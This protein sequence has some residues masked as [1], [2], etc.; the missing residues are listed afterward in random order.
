MPEECLNCSQKISDGGF[1]SAPNR[2]L[3]F[4]AVKLANFV[5]DAHYE[6]LCEACGR[7]INL[8]VQQKLATEAGERN[9]YLQR[10]APEFPMLTVGVL[11][12]SNEYCALGMVT[13]NVAVGTGLFNEFSQ[14]LSDLFG[15]VNEQSGMAFKVNK[16]EAAARSILVRKALAMGANAIIGVDIDYGVTNNNAAT[17]NIQGTAV[18]VPDLATLFGEKTAKVADW[19]TWTW[20]RAQ[21]L[22]RWSQG[23][24]HDGEVYRAVPP[25]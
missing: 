1:L 10:T 25:Q 3:S 7:D 24:I 6:A 9:G 4:E 17:V 20:D 5:Q 16:G 14:G 21:K 2:P 19:I 18:I 11:P 15:A 22:R 23:D 8:A 13:A 12:G